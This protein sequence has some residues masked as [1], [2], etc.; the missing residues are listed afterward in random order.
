MDYRV[1]KADIRFVVAV[2]LVSAG[3]GAMVSFLVYDDWRG[4]LV[5]TAFFPAVW[6][7]GWIYVM[8]RRRK[9]LKA[10]FREMIILFS[11]NLEAGYSLENAIAE[12]SR[13]FSDDNKTNS[14][15]QGELHRF[16]NGIACGQAV[17]ELFVKF[18]VRSGVQ[19]IRDFAGLLKIAKYY[20]GNIP[21]LIRQTAANFADTAMVETEIDTLISAKRLE[22]RIMLAVPFAILGYLRLMNPEYVQPLYTAGGRVWMT[23]GLLIIGAAAVWIEKIVRI[24]V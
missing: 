13:M 4:M 16:V 12:T 1:F 9:E 11:G 22:G 5:T 18:G 23:I 17:D 21:K 14:I 20:G 3:L 6:K 10:E 8:Q 24:E 7:Q 19:E 2:L 15:M